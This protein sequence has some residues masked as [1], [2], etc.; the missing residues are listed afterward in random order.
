MSQ[1]ITQPSQLVRITQLV[2]LALFL[3]C[4]GHRPSIAA[5]AA[6]ELSLAEFQAVFLSK[7]LP[8]VIW[9]KEVLPPEDQPIV[10]GLLGRDPFDGLLQKLV[11]TQE[12]NGR[13]ITVRI[14]SETNRLDKC[15]VVF[16]P[17]DKMEEWSRLKSDMDGRGVLAVGADDTGAFLEGGGVFNLLTKERKLEIN[18]RNAEKVGLKIGAKLLKISKVL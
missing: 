2:V 13:R 10:I 8:Y 11:E 18:R 3:L 12:T 1:F 4:C 6:S 16:V 7:L 9:S 14:L 5:D 15:N 17:P